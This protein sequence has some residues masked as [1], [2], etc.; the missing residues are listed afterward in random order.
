M[1]RCK[2]FSR[3]INLYFRVLSAYAIDDLSDYFFRF[4]LWNIIACGNDTKI[5]KNNSINMITYKNFGGKNYYTGYTRKDGS[6][7]IDMAEFGKMLF[8]M[9]IMP[10]G[11]FF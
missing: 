7:R 8:V 11:C 2:F 3:R 5:N 4:I 1:S 6:P 10:G 9:L